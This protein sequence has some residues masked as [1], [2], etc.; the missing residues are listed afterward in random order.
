M[1]LVYYEVEIKKKECRIVIFLRLHFIPV[2][3][4]W[5]ALQNMTIMDIL[6]R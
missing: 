1:L 4:M 3:Q 5:N 2:H 6:D